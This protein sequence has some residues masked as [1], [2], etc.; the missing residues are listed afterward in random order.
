MNTVVLIGRTARDPEL[1]R[2]SN[3]TA[4]TSF[5]LAVNRDFKT[6]DGQEADFI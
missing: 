6:N 4:V 3:G 1:R 5:T 2:T